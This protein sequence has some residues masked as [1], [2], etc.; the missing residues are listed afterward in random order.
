MAS[1]EQ[2]SAT[3]HARPE[4]AT[5]SDTDPR[6]D[7]APVREQVSLTD[8]TTVVVRSVEPDDADA[9][10][11]G[12][13]QLSA[14]S[15]Y[16]RFFTTYPRLSPAQVRYFTA[17]D[18]HDHEALGAVTAHAGEGIGIARYIRDPHDPLSAEL[19]IVILD[20]WQRLGVGAQLMRVLCDRARDE[21]ITTLVAEVL[22]DNAALPALL[23]RFGTVHTH[24]SGT[25]T[26]ATLDLG[27][28]AGR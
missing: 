21:G 15:A 17:V 28:R 4:P 7:E 24:T 12:Y 16:R 27:D 23:R 18:H 26:H 9:L 2:P 19:A 6:A 13:Q 22:T 3:E 20:T 11:A 10:A 1:D 5:G 8:G 14:T 25:T